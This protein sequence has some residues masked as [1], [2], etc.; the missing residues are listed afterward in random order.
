MYKIGF[1]GGGEGWESWVF[2]HLDL[3][4]GR[5]AG[6]QGAVASCCRQNTAHQVM[7]EVECQHAS[8]GLSENREDGLMGG[9]VRVGG[10]AGW[11]S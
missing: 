5:F 2:P 4:L 1:G 7:K 10:W 11:C 8:M 3:I 6:A 9:W